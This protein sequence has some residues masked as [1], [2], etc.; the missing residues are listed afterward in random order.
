MST[1]L[2][3]DDRPA[4]R[5]FLLTLLGY[6]GHRVLEASDGAQALDLARAEHPDLVITDI[7]MPTM[8]GY[9]FAFN[10]RRDPGLAGTP[11]VFY[12]ATYNSPEARLLAQSC[13]VRTV[14][15]KPAEPEE[16]LG[17]VAREL[18]VNRS[19]HPAVPAA[20]GK[21]PKAQRAGDQAGEYLDD[22]Q[23]VRAALDKGL[24]GDAGPATDQAHAISERLSGHIADLQ[25][26]TSRLATL[27]EI[28]MD[29]MSVSEPARMVEKFFDAACRMIP[30]DCAALGLFNETD[31]SLEYL[32]TK[33]I[34]PTIYDRSA[35]TGRPAS[36]AREHRFLRLE[37]SQLKTFP[38]GHPS[39]RSFLGGPVV[40]ADE[41]HGWL[42]FANTAPG[43]P[44][45]A[46]DERI[47][48]TLGTMLALL[49]EHVMLYDTVQRHAA[50][51]Q[52]EVSGR[53]Q[54]EAAVRES[55]AKFRELI[56]HASD[57]VFVTDPQGDFKLV[58]RRFCEML[59]YEEPELLRLNVAETYVEAE[60]GLLAQRLADL[61]EVR[62]RLFERMIRRKDGSTFPIEV[63]IRRL[64]NGMN[65]GIVRDI[66]ERKRAAQALTESEA[67]FRQ[68]AES[69]RDVYFLTDLKTG[70]MLYVSPAYENIW[71]RSCDSLH[72]NPGSWVESIHPEDR[73]RVAQKFGKQQTTGR[74][75]DEYRIVRPDGEVRWI[76]A[77]TFAIPDE[78]GKPYRSAGV[79]ED[80]TARRHAENRIRALNRVYAVLSGINALIVRAKTQEELF[81]GA[82]R[83]AVEDGRFVMAWI[84]LIGQDAKRIHPAAS[85]GA[86]GDFFEQAP[87]AMGQNIE[88][89]EGLAPRAVRQRGPVFSNDIQNDSRSTMI[90]ACRER[91]IHSV[92][93]LP[94]LVG[95]EAAGVLGLYARERGFFDGEE[96][97]LLEELAGDISFALDHIEKSSRLD[98]LAYYD[99]TTG[100]ANRKL[101]LERADQRIRIA[102][103]TKGRLALAILDIERFKNLNDTLGRHTGDQLLKALAERFMRFLG[104]P[105]RIGRVLGDQFGIIIPDVQ[106]EDE[107]A[108]RIDRKLKECVGV[109]MRIGE[110]E[111]RI[112]ARVGV[113]LYPEDGADADALFRNAEAALKRA[114]AGGERYLFYTQQMT[115]RVGEKLALENKLRLALEKEEFVLH[116]QPKVDASTRK[117]E[118]LEA[119]IRWQSRELGLVPP[120]EF[121]PLLEET[122][123]I[124]EVGAWALRRAALDYRRW[125]GQGLKAPRVAVN[126]SAIQVRRS[127]FVE[128]T[129]ESMKQDG[130]RSVI[131]LEVT[132]SLI[133]GD[134][135]AN[136]GKFEALRRSGLEIAI[137]DFGT[138]YSSLAY[139][140]KLP[141]QLLKIDRSFVN[142]MLKDPAV[143]TLVSTI[144]SL[145]H[146]LKLKVV[147][148]GV[149]TEAQANALKKLGCDQ[150]QGYLVGRPAP[151]EDL[152]AL[153]SARGKRR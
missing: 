118:G 140:A 113:A 145:A 26:L 31:R 78:A 21:T 39:M 148:E 111:L 130:V 87:L 6:T 86:V 125:L 141:V 30:S 153:L 33:G 127:D 12:S 101:L 73:D 95:S 112:S 75:D 122:G 138:G 110:N 93:F 135:V 120:M 79:A 65:Q 88:S 38:A 72:A 62:S 18:G 134:I 105:D 25:R 152:S 74:F 116:Y 102:A 3:V 80:I 41:A 47:A 123:L 94:L 109:P 67:R 142:S 63:S 114:K 139:L 2:V 90:A 128:T 32:F 150:L 52:I 108:R 23:A 37:E 36:L 58:N 8:D 40:H 147:A 10:I 66:T 131:D 22:L 57:G 45:I 34:D 43:K 64:S 98:Y 15:R 49:Y 46:E 76:H 115:E 100:V 133:M 117:I 143:M 81:H 5:E 104:D 149:E 119:L 1:I 77:R 144:V 4:N 146:T 96:M 14:L 83:I 129:L 71:G 56:E 92:A 91:D 99:A 51:L 29:M 89:Q 11:I 103:E 53:K 55:E 7:L 27:T 121:I 61:G 68:M 124:L 48:G 44:F 97:K 17:V 132:E 84:G 137:D 9:E 24:S 85:A 54:A 126:V 151:F 70:G 19:Q 82:C 35:R 13:G 59:A 20:Q 28:A 50:R 60:R 136:I 42:Y 69:M 107:V 16:L 106:S